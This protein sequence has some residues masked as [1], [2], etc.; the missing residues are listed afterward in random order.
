MNNQSPEYEA[1][2]IIGLIFLTIIYIMCWANTVQADEIETPVQTNQY[3]E[4]NPA[5][6][7]DFEVTK[8][9]MTNAILQRLTL[10]IDSDGNPLYAGSCRRDA[11]GCEARIAAIVDYIVHESYVQGVDPWLVAAQIW[12]ESRFYPFARGGVG[13]RGVMQLH[14]RNRRFRDVLFVHSR[15]HRTRCRRVV[16]NCQQEVIRE[17]VHLLRESIDHCGNEWRGLTMY[18]TGSCTFRN[19]Y[20]WRIIRECRVFLRLAMQ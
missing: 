6:V 18:N 15:P 12:K 7:Q 20:A 19:R 3:Q 5:H 8:V 13:E 1:G 10:R 4:C 11:H 17:G 2:I 9:L 14:P 16:G